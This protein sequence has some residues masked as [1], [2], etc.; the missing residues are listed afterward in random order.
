V[1][2]LELAETCLVTLRPKKLKNAML[3][4]TTT[5]DHNTVGLSIIWC[6]P[7]GRSKKV[8]RDAHV[9]RTGMKI[10]IVVAPKNPSRP[11]A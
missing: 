1:R 10:T 7:R 11:T 9:A 4:A 6:Q 3:R 8:E 2:D 5:P